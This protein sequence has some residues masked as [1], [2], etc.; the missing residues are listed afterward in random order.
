MPS[1]VYRTS[2]LAGKFFAARWGHAPKKRG[3]AGRCRVCNPPVAGPS[4]QGTGNFKRTEQGILAR[5]WSGSGNEQVARTRPRNR[6]PRGC[7]AGP[8]QHT[9]ERRMRSRTHG[10]AETSKNPKAF[11]RS[12]KSPSSSG[13]LRVKP[14]ATRQSRRA[15]KTRATARGRGGSRSRRRLAPG[16]YRAAKR[17]RASGRWRSAVERA[18]RR[19]T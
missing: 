6:T 7:I 18:V 16:R 9:A 13:H 5:I 10:Q 1:R 2:L 15:V 8:S 11:V 19:A 3:I 14:A 4:R 17:N 12:V